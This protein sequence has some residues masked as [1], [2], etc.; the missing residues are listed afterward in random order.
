MIAKLKKKA[1]QE[2]EHNAYCES[3]KK[4][5]SIKRDDQQRKLDGFAARLEKAKAGQAD[6]KNDIATLGQELADLSSA[7]A[8]ATKVREQE[9][10]DFGHN[11]EGFRIATEGLSKAIGVLREYYAAEGS[12]DK[13]TDSSSGIVAMLETLLQDVSNC[14]AQ[15]EIAE[16][17]AQQ[18]Y[19]KMMQGGKVSKAEKTA[20][21]KAKTAELA[22]LDELTSDLSNDV[23]G[24]QAELDATL[25][26]LSKLKNMCTHKPQ[27]F[28]DRAAARQA[29]IAGLKQA[30]E[31]LESETS[32]MQA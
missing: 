26:Y 25:Q 13:K 5:N 24:A 28:E 16:T 27:T 19:D 1:A 14:Q 2:A 32:F 18:S 9:S 12:H 3:E 11:A 29:E 6:L 4:D 7:M 30:L 21:S 31:I 10:S 22:R 15:A 17:N 23:D 20:N 8:E